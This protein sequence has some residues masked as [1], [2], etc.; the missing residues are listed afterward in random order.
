MIGTQAAPSPSEVSDSENILLPVGPLT[1]AVDKV[2][3]VKE[4]YPR[5]RE[6]D[7]AIERYRA[8]I[9][10]LP[11]ITVARDGILVD[12]FHRLQ[13]HRRENIEFIPAENLGNLSDAEIFNESIRRNAAH[14]QQL[15][16]KDKEA[17]AGKLWATYA[18]LPNAERTATIAGVLA[19]GERTVQGWTKDARKAEKEVMQATAWDLWLDCNTQEQ[20]AD[21]VGVTQPTA[22]E[23]IIDFRK[24]AESYTAP[25]S[26]QHFDVWNFH[27]ATGDSSYFGKMPPQVVENLLWLYTEPGQI[28]FDPFAGGGT[29]IDVAKAMGRRVWSSDRKPSTPTL[30]IH[31]HDIT[32]G[33]PDGAPKKA[34]FVLLDPPYWIQAAGRYSDAPEDLGNMS[35]DD[36]MAAWAGIVRTCAD[37]LSDGGRLAFIVSPAED[38]ANDRVVDLAYLMAKKCEDA[39]LS[40]ERRIIVTYTTQQATGQQVEWA[41]ENR[42]ML[43]LYRD[44]VVF[45]K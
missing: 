45:R 27:K 32:T 1:I 33:W 8:S 6:D 16:R 22:R 20:I 25:G 21:V 43:K 37:R 42:K 5:L 3:F 38:K 30:P 23:W 11:P 17:L 2:R 15:S 7:A 36:F 13:A 24:S 31:E 9:D 19:V 14:G 28:V 41:R 34:D 35:L 44:L 18:H 39:G 12:G 29:T 26:R 10:L 40:I 4:L